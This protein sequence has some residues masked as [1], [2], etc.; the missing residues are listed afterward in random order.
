MP[1]YA[2]LYPV[3]LMK[4]GVTGVVC[5][6]NLRARR[7]RETPIRKSLSRKPWTPKLFADIEKYA[8]KLPWEINKSQN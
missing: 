1:D 7:L 6:K 8:G 2:I 3:P 4:T 5:K